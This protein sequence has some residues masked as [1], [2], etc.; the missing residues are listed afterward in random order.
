MKILITGGSGFIGTNLIEYYLLEKHSILNIDFKKPMN[1]KQKQFWKNIDI[2]D[3]NDLDVAFSEFMPDYVV[4]LAAR[5]DLRGKTIKDYDTNTLGVQNIIAACGKCSSIKKVIFTSTMLVCK[6]GYY[7]K[8]DSDYCP[9]NLYGES[10]MLGEGIVRQDSAGMDYDWSIVRPTSIWGPW[11]GVTYRDFFVM[12]IKR[13]YINFSGK[14]STKTYGY[15]DNT[16]YQI[17]N[18]LFSEKTN[19]KTYYLGDYTPTNIS[20]WASEIS[21]ELGYELKSVPLLIILI[22]SYFGEFLKLFN[23]SFPLNKF[24][25]KNMTTDNIIPLQDTIDVAP[26]LPVGRL[27]GIKHTIKWLNDFYLSKENQIPK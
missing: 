14:S 24:R 5:A 22:A 7:P 26:S 2:R 12:L 4:H 11:F 21:N 16:I 3:S 1:Q 10:K 8:T 9:P 20:K 15:I 13:K 23:I 6:V 17:N 27:V 19:S 18:I 25:Y